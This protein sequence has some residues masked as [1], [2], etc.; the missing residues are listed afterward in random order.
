[1]NL[2]YIIGLVGA[3]AVFLFGCVSKVV[4]EPEFASSLRFYAE[5]EGVDRRGAYQQTV[6]FPENLSGG[7]IFEQVRFNVYCNQ[8]YDILRLTNYSSEEGLEVQST[9]KRV[10]LFKDSFNCVVIPFL[11]LSY[12]EVVCI[13]LRIYKGDVKAL[14]QEFRPDMVMVSYNIGAIAPSNSIM[15]E[16]PQ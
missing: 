10:L 13:D 9:S 14:I 7:S 2:T 12:D 1:M 8:D 15:F 5:N 4:I 11:A 16:F 3:F 6:L